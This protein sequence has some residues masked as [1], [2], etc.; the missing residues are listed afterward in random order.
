MQVCRGRMHR[1][2]AS[3]QDCAAVLPAALTVQVLATYGHVR[4]LPAKQGS[5]DPKA[6]KLLATATSAAGLD[7]CL[8]ASAPRRLGAKA[9]ICPALP[10][11]HS[12]EHAAEA[13]SKPGPTSFAAGFA[14]SW[15]LSKGAEARM[16]GIAAA[17]RRS[18]H[19]VLATDPDREGEAISWHLLQELQVGG[20]GRQ[21]PF[22][23]LSP[24]KQ[25]QQQRPC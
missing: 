18:R 23:W 11:P 7:A 3:A 14:M 25:Q 6:G 24:V 15:Q 2:I 4:D 10:V 1:A 13:L 22:W 21:R 16:A 20:R 12:C 17:V 9:A 19:L 8:R 5:V